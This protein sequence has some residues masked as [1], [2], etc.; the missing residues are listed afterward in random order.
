MTRV[1]E[2]VEVECDFSLPHTVV[3]IVHHDSEVETIDSGFEHF[4]SYVRNATYFVPMDSVQKIKETAVSCEQFLLVECFFSQALRN[5][6]WYGINGTAM[7][8]VI[9]ATVSDPCE[10]VLRDGACV[11]MGKTELAVNIV[12]L[13][14]N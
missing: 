2:A 10:C 13:P 7:P 3:T 5:S 11:A 4:A 8:Y 14:S 9:N 12:A 6:F 1:S